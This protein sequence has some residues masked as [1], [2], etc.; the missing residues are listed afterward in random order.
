MTEQE[1]LKQIEELKKQLEEIQANKEV[2][3]KW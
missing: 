2:G 3:T 1:I